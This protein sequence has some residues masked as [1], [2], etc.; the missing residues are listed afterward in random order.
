MNHALPVACYCQRA[1][2]VLSGAVLGG[3]I[4]F[5]CGTSAVADEHHNRSI[6]DPVSTA[7]AIPAPSVNT[8]ATTRL[9]LPHVHNDSTPLAARDSDRWADL[10]TENDHRR[11][12]ANRVAEHQHAVDPD[13]HAKVHVGPAPSAFT[14]ES[15]SR[16]RYDSESLA[17]K[18]LRPFRLPPT[19]YF[20]ESTANTRIATGP[21][22]SRLPAKVQE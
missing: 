17:Q 9:W 10:S 20:D 5:A 8:G 14:P 1:K 18:H 11:S 21:Q 3:A 4:C 13:L 6:G 7:G 2:M 19:G 15:F 12:A 22:G 16:T